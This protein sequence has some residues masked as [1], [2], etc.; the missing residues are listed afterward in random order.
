M[1]PLRRSYCST[2]GERRWPKARRW[3]N[4]AIGLVT[5]RLLRAL[6]HGENRILTVSRV[7]DGALGLHDVALSLPAIVG[8]N[9]VVEV[10]PPDLS[11]DER[12]RLDRSVAVHL[13]SM[14]AGPDATVPALS[15]DAPRRPR[16][17]DPRT[18]RTR[19]DRMSLSQSARN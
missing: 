5:A 18:V 13:G 1:P 11:D 12:E 14:I 19:M 3:I 8:L 7:H 6:L 4:Y 9:G 10:V 2:I 17:P 16:P 15:S